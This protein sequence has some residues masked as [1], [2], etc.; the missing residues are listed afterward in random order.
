M[1]K[2]E[3]IKLKNWLFPR[4]DIQIGKKSIPTRFWLHAAPKSWSKYTTNNF[5]RL[6]TFVVQYNFIE[7][8]TQSPK[9]P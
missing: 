8:V 6:L 5:S 4:E 9:Q 7:C 3:L 1:G 2:N